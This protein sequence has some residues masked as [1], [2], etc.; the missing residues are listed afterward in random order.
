MSTRAPEPS[1]QRGPWQRL[2]R[3]RWQRI[4]QWRHQ[5]SRQELINDALDLLAFNG[6]QG[7][8]VEFGCHGAETLPIAYRVSSQLR[9]K[10][11]LW[12]IDHFQGIPAPREFRDLHPRW[13]EG[14]RLTT[15]LQFRKLCTRAGVPEHAYRLIHAPFDQLGTLDRNT[16]PDN[17]AMAWVNCHL[18]SQVDAVL[19]FLEPRLKQGMILAFDH[20]F[21]YTR[22]HCSGDRSALLSLQS[23]AHGF[24]VC[25]YRN[26]G[27]T[28]AA[29]VV[30]EAMA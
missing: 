27:L 2:Q 12:A 20:Y 21:A 13:Q 14:E 10:R 17:I 9:P 8:Y 29:F 25:P 24:R 16:V 15:E 19:N 5:R 3:W 6:I 7:D 11:Q 22:F 18:H 23:G 30:E 26:F 28:G 1:N 4:Q